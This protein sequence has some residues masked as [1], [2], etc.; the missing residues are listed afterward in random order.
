MLTAKIIDFSI[1]LE[2][3]VVFAHFAWSDYD[4]IFRLKVVDLRLKESA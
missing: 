3:L 4:T 2:S 1:D